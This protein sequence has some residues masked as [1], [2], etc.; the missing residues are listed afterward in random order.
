[1]GSA[2]RERKLTVDPNGTSLKPV[3]HPNRRVQILSMHRRSQ[4]IRS[5]I[6]QPNSIRLILELGNSCNRPKD[7][8]LHDLHLLRDIRKD[9]R[10]DEIPLITMAITP[11]D[12][13]SALLLTRRNIP[14]N[15][16]ILQ[17]ADLRALESLRVERVADLV[18]EGTL[19][20]GRD[21]LV[22]DALLDIDARSRAAALAVVVVDA[23]VDP[24]DG[25]FDVGV[26]EDNIG[27]FAAEFE[28]DFLE[29][30]GRRGLH[31][32]AADEGGAREGD[33]VDVH[34]C[35]EGRARGLAEA[36][37]DVEDAWG[38]TGFFDEAGEDEG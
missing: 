17:L 37:D 24:A 36:G 8:L 27:G 38:E 34:V 14:H 23:K 12:N 18:F 4:T 3:A 35:G 2:L 29:V 26:V 1:M 13:R 16:V 22:V 32:S 10:L 21:E 30:G 31:D 33:L 11:R 28:G 20:K 5:I 19:L 6:T 25:L 15:T 7:L 9:G